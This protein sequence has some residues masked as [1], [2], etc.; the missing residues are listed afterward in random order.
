M[1]LA[2][3]YGSVTY[4]VDLP[5]GI[6]TVEDE[7]TSMYAQLEIQL[8]PGFWVTPEV[9]VIDDKEITGPAGFKFEEGDMTYY[10]AVWKIHF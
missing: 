2:V 5:A 7:G 8:A 10:G 6:G 9:G 3:G 1:K 4:E